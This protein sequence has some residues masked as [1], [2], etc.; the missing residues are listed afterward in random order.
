MVEISLEKCLVA[1]RHQRLKLANLHKFFLG[2]HP[3]GRPATVT[4]TQKEYGLTSKMSEKNHSWYGSKQNVCD[5][6]ETK[7]HLNQGPGAEAN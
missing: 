1:D 5:S 3:Q 7:C 2:C 6:T 4:K